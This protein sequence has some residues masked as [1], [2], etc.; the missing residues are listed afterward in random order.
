MNGNDDLQ[1]R[2]PERRLDVRSAD[3]TRLNVEVHGAETDPAVLLIHGWTCSV[4][5]WVRQID[6]LLAEGYRVVAYD[7]RGHGASDVPGPDGPT[8]KALAD[9]LAAVLDAVLDPG[10]QAVI[11]GH[12]MGAMALVAFG[13]RYPAQLR[14]QVAGA[15][16][17]STGMHQ[18]VL[19]SRILPLPLPLAKLARP[20][21]NRL[22][23]V[24]PGAGKGRVTPFLRIMIK[25]GSLSRT[26][27]REEVEFCARIVL[28]C[29]PATRGAFGRMISELDLDRQVG[30]LDV[31]AVVV[32]GTHDRLTPIW[33]ARRLAARLPQLI[34]FLEVAGA[35][36]M[37]PVQAAGEVDAAL[38][39]LAREYLPRVRSSGQ[40]GSINV[41]DLATRYD[42]APDPGL[43]VEPDVTQET[44]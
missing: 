13:T 28:A 10:E 30:E 23:S 26:A 16:L 15:M 11:G 29:R 20:I 40:D 9:D 3:G 44:A 33:H 7:Q 37:T 1:L 39:R 32:A 42:P 4:V 34:G 36:H 19:R 38:L 25:Y 24:S 35:G 31:P 18:L 6:A 8:I 43:A 21:S 2:E 5:F 22:V 12:S 14:R 17:A 41:I 27:T